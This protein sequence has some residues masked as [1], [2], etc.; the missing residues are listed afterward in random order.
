MPPYNRKLM[1]YIRKN[2]D[3]LQYIQ[4]N[5]DYRPTS[6]D[7]V[8]VNCVFCG[9]SDYKLYINNDTKRFFCF[10]CQKSNGNSDL[11]DL[12]AAAENIS[13]RDAIERTLAQYKSITPEELDLYETDTETTQ[14]SSFHTIKYISGMPE[15]SVLFTDKNEESKPYI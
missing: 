8:R 14:E 12:I 4:D 3:Y 11:F 6:S 1:R 15:D 13:I 10:K 2:F 7:E 9:E 5:L